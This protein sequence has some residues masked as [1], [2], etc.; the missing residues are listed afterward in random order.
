M[1]LKKLIALEQITARIGFD[2]PN[3]ESVID[4]VISECDEIRQTVKDNEGQERLQEEIGDLIHATISLCFFSEFD[5]EET[6]S[7]VSN[8]FE[9]RLNALE[10]IMKKRG[11]KTLKGETFDVLLDLWDEA[12][13]E[14]DTVAASSA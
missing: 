12:K 6:L 14:G 5:V 3:A 1:P 11:I 10:S 8:K 4:Q 2:W 13:R 9:K 7:I